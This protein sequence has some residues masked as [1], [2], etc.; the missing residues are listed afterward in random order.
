MKFQEVEK[1][2]I[3]L[4]GDIIDYVANAVVIKTIL[5]KHTGNIYFMS[6]DSGEGLNEKSSPFDTFLEVVDGQ[7][8]MVINGESGFL[9]TGQSILIPAHTFYLIKPYVRF[10]MILTIF[11]SSFE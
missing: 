7:A 8:H 6:V 3:L 1:S 11:K 4:T 2:K 5:K 10:K 9:K